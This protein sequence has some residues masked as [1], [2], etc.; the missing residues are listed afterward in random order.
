M[1]GIYK[2]TNL[3][4]GKI[5]IGQSIHLSIRY[6]QHKNRYNDK[7]DTEYNHSFHT[8]IRK[9]GW[10]N[11]KY[12]VL[13]DNDDLSLEDLDNLESYYIDYYDSYNSGYNEDKGGSNAI[14]PRK[15]DEESAL[16]LKEEI[17]NTNITFTELSKKYNISLGMVSDINKGNHWSFVGNFT[18]P[19]RNT[20]INRNKGQS[21]PGAHFTDE[22]V[23]QIRTEYIQEDLNSL[24]EKYK[25]KGISY[26][27]FRK[28]IFGTSFP[29][30]PYY[31]KREKK[32]YQFGTCIDYSPEGK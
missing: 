17:K 11:F 5:Y 32:W 20:S 4:N 9:Y 29:H 3:I 30:V 14:H 7:N 31:K 6:N 21:H 10:E 26:S 15:L 18:Y 12:E 13:I 23:L 28:I 25:N 1:K 8:A 24:Y 27:A 2:Y 16:K 19:I 22:E